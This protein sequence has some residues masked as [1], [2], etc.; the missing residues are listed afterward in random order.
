MSPDEPESGGNDPDR[1]WARAA[2]EVRAY[3]EAQR[4]R[5][6]DLD[7]TAI[8]RFVA[9]GATADERHRVLGAM[10]RHPE[11]RECIETVQAIVSAHLP[12]ENVAFES[13]GLPTDSAAP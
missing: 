5:W 6:G 1:L 4:S 2:T 10:H 13:L 12:E 7:E 3:R 9:G 11:L 8:A